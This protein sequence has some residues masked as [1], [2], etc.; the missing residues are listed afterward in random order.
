MLLPTRAWLTA[1]PS[2]ALAYLLSFA[3]ALSSP[4]HCNGWIFLLFVLGVVFFSGL[5]VLAQRPAAAASGSMSGVSCLGLGCQPPTWG[6]HGQS[7]TVASA[8]IATDQGTCSDIGASVLAANGSAVDAAVAAALCL[9][10]VHPHSSGLGGGCFILVYDAATGKA[11]AIDAREAAPSAATADMFVGNPQGALL[12]GNAS[13]VPGEL[14]GLYLAWQ[15]YGKLPWSRLVLP[16]ASLADGFVVDG[17]L[18]GAIVATRAAVAANPALAAVLMP[19]GQ[20]LA[21]GQT[22]ANPALAATL[23][24]VAADGPAAFYGAGPAA[25]MAED[26]RAAGGILTADDV[27]NYR[28]ASA[29]ALAS[30]AWGMTFLTAPPPSS[31]GAAV[32]LITDFLSGY[33]QPLASAGGLGAHR[34]VEALKHAFAAR[35]A[36]APDAGDP[37]QGALLG[38][39]TDP[40]WAA[41]LRAATSD[42]L[43]APP[44]SYGNP[45]N[46]LNAAN[47]TAGQG[48]LP[49]DAGTT[50]VSVV[51]AGRSAV[52]LTST[53]N[54][55]FGSC[56]M[57]RSGVVMNNECA[58][59]A[60]LSQTAPPP[61]S[62]ATCAR[63]LTPLHLLFLPF[64]SVLCSAPQDGRLQHARPAERVRPAPVLSQPRGPLSAAPLLHVPHRRPQRGRNPARGGGRVRRAAHHQ[65]RAPSVTEAGVGTRE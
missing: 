7:V 38:N 19:G 34:T 22:C 25:A 48:G 3:L 44:Q 53:V 26:V 55:L 15:T 17:Q 59:A 40:G 23:R 18:A 61:R 11:E 4:D 2:H 21:A 27:L 62:H 45:F 31:G 60:S 20:P 36:M 46:P 58:V 54:T 35:L 30:S 5:M 9:G 1:A 13:A 52:A 12:G 39:M 65:A 37:G 49:P 64:L 29:P 28:A 47:P 10:V 33:A 32:A 56:V 6:N 63:R 57:T 16:A 50:H 41:A 14:A 42:V 43:T 8:A 24:A 51:D